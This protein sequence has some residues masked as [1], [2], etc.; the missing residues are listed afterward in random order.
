MDSKKIA[1]RKNYK[2]NLDGTNRTGFNKK[3]NMKQI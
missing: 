3:W 2:K 1:I